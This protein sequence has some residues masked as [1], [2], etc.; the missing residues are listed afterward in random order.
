MNWRKYLAGW[1][2][3]IWATILVEY[4]FFFL[5]LAIMMWLYPPPAT[6]P[7][8]LLIGITFALVIPWVFVSMKIGVYDKAFQLLREGRD[9]R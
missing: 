1:V 6:P 9:E 7:I 8:I 3:A 2:Y 5:I 4:S